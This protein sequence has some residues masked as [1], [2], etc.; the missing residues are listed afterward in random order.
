MRYSYPVRLRKSAN[1]ILVSFRD[2]PEAITF[3]WDRDEALVSAVDCLDVALLFRLKNSE[4]IPEPSEPKRGEIIIPASP[5]VAAKVAFALAFR[6]SG[7]SRVALAKRLGWAESE[8]RRLLDPNHATKLD[9]ID[10]AL[11]ALGRRL[12]V[13]DAP[14]AA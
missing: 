1:S 6:E 11:R 9:R 10:V 3:G 13:G 7:L 12:V 5:Q 4:S 8:I 2:L 14:L